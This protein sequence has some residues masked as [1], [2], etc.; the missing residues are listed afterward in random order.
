M[1]KGG[2]PAHKVSKITRRLIPGT[3]RHTDRQTDNLTLSSD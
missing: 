3:D 1:Q 2:M